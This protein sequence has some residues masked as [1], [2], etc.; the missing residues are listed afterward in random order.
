MKQNRIIIIAVLALAVITAG[1]L[2]LWL[3]Q[4]KQEQ[5][6]VQTAEAPPKTE[7][8]PSPEQAAPPEKEKKKAPRLRFGPKHGQSLAYRFESESDAVIDFSLLMPAGMPGSKTPQLASPSSSKTPA[9]SSKTAVR[10]KAS[11]ELRLKYYDLEPGIWNV[12]AVLSDVEY[13]LNDRAPAYSEGMTY[14]FVF[15]SKYYATDPLFD[16]ISANLGLDDALKM[17]GELRK[18][19][20]NNAGRYAEKFFVNYLR[21]HPEACFDLVKVMNADPRRERLDHSAQLILWRLITEAGHTEAQQA[22]VDVIVNPEMS[23][24]THIRGLAYV[25][26][27]ENPQEFVADAIWAFYKGTDPG[28]EDQDEQELR[29][30]SLYAFGS[31]GSDDKINE[32]VKPEISERLVESL[33]NAGEPREQSVTLAAIGNYGGEEVIDAIEPYFS[34]ED[35]NVRASA[36]DALRRMR[37]PKAAETLARH[38]ETEAS[39]EVRIAALR[40]LKAM[41]PVPEG[42]NWASRTVLVTEEPREQELL[43]NV[44]GENL[45]DHPENEK[46]L[47][48]LLKK[49]PTNRVKREIYKYIVPK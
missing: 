3:G 19:H 16:E 10:L 9:Q 47:R 13:H 48:E 25:H 38:Y 41:P 37:D 29:T 26:D 17:Y 33:Y 32:A 43:V 40:T 35:E 28:T 42:V 24:L 7:P 34:S 49:E 11:G 31:L 1:T 20:T 5:S 22:I 14:P 30:M 46:T 23:N 39:H 18:K 45:R 4:E 15:R 8:A 27:F 44:V 36:Y 12:A 21:Q 6:P 2:G